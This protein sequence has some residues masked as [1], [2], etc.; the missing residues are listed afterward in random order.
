MDAVKDWIS[1][2]AVNSLPNQPSHLAGRFSQDNIG[3]SS[4][5]LCP[6]T[7]LCCRKAIT[8]ASKRLMENA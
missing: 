6:L 1:L 8:I 7:L 3:K 5:D 2:R 4:V